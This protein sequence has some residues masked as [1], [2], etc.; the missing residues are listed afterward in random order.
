MPGQRVRAVVDAA[1][2]RVEVAVQ[3]GRL[4]GLEAVQFLRRAAEAVGLA[5]VDLAAAAPTLVDHDRAQ[6]GG[7]EPLGGARPGG[8]G[9]DDN[10]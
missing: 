1:R 10:R 9:A 8:A 7:D 4:A 5:A 3:G 6:A 2:Q